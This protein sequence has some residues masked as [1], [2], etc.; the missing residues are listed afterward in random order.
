[1]GV[2]RVLAETAHAGIPYLALGGGEPMAHPQFWEICAFAAEHGIQVKI[3]TDGRLIDAGSARKMARLG[4]KSIQL[5]LDGATPAVYDRV[6]PGGQ[7]AQ[8]VA[9]LRHL[10]DYEVPV[11]VLFV[12]TCLN[13]DDI[14]AVI[15]LAV[16]SGARGFL[17]GPLMRIGRAANHWRDLAPTQRQEQA[18][19][20]TIADRTRKW[21]GRFQMRVYPWDIV[22][23][24]RERSRRP[25]AMLLVVPNGMVKLLNAL[26]FVCANLR[27]HTMN[28]AWDRY[29]RAWSLPIVRDFVKRVPREPRLLRLANQTIPLELDGSF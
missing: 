11:D 14:G 16:E 26:P 25:Q 22:R 27:V 28:E 6:R 21:R 1:V 10:S 12:P 29:L 20:K 15:D 9:A 7:F 4:I 3:E 5:S 17:T 19:K 2:R 23:E 18:M 8:A 24:I 13:A